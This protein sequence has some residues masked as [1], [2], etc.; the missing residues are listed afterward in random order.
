MAKAQV[1]KPVYEKKKALEREIATLGTS[2]DRARQ[3]A[4]EAQAAVTDVETRRK[5]LEQLVDGLVSD[6][7]QALKVLEGILGEAARTSQITQDALKEAK[8]TLRSYEAQI[9]RETA[10]LTEI[11]GQHRRRLAEIDR[12]N[13]A[14]ATKQRDVEIMVDRIRKRAKELGVPANI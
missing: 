2:R 14:V 11:R 7:N 3:K 6:A 9:G 13:A 1:L 8:A 4:E 5:E 12:E 10:K